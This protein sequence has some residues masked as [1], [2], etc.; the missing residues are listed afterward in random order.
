M[1]KRATDVVGALVGAVLLS[2][3]LAAI[4]LVIRTRDGS[5]VLFRQVR[6]GRDGRP[7]RILKFRTM[8]NGA[9]PG[10]TV[11]GDARVTDVGRIL[12]RFK[13][14]ELPQLFNVLSG[15]MSLVGPRPELPE[16]V[17]QWPAATR[18][19]VLSVRPGITDPAAVEFYD[20][21]AILAT[22][23]DPIEAYRTVLMPQKLELYSSY[24]QTRTF[25]TDLR[26]IVATLRRAAS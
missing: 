21:E 10:V 24:I 6:V 5:P 4:A 22:Y 1:I 12:R 9:G 26:V 13:L 23:P 7:F 3:V 17:A 16:Y 8:T 2:P 18:D 15:T 11:A 14:D 25:T 20:E 19:V